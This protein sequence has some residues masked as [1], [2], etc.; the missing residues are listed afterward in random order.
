MFNIL[1]SLF[2]L[3]FTATSYCNAFWWPAVFVAEAVKDS[4]YILIIVSV[5]IEACAYYWFLKTTYQKALLYS[6]IGNI[7]ST[8]LGTFLTTAAM[9]IGLWQTLYSPLQN[10]FDSFIINFL[11]MFIG[12]VLIELVVI[13][14]ISGYSFKQLLLPVLI[15]NF[16]TYAL[17]IILYF[18]EAKQILHQLYQPKT[19][20]P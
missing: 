3:F 11:V 13:K 7:A 19:K 14:L 12:S 20:Y 10:I 6:V 17:I 18:N 9:G 16:V 15:G 8:I 1:A 5:V 4:F 2:C